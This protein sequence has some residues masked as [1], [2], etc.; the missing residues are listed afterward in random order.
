MSLLE[1]RGPPVGPVRL[2]CY[3]KSLERMLTVS[4]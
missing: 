3:P 2:M 4:L 1:A